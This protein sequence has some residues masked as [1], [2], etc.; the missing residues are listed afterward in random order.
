MQMKNWKNSIYE[1]SRNAESFSKYFEENSGQHYEC[2]HREV[3]EVWPNIY[4]LK[5]LLNFEL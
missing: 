3:C 2:V 4:I 5:M 1:Q